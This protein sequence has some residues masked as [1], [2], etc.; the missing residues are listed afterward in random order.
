MLVFYDS[1]ERLVV[2]CVVYDCVSLKVLDIQSFCFKPDSSIF[3][4]PELISVELIDFSCKDDF[5]GNFFKVSSIFKKIC[6]GASFSSAKQ[7]FNDF[8]VAADGNSL[9]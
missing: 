3:K 2:A 6:V 1:C 4:F 9:K 7:P 5:V 8:V